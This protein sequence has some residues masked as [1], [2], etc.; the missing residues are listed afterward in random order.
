MS[1]NENEYIYVTPREPFDS[2][3]LLQEFS[4][5]HPEGEAFVYAAEGV[6]FEVAETA[7]VVALIER[8]R[9]KRTTAPVTV[10][11]EPEATDEDAADPDAEPKKTT[12]GRAAGKAQE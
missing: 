10:A 12:R 6:V 9:L 1:D 3:V 5:E 7:G 4:P 2:V 11:P 8:K